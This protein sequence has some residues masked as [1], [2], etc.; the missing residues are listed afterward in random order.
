MVA[1]MKRKA[2]IKNADKLFTSKNKLKDTEEDVEE[3]EDAEMEEEE[4]LPDEEVNEEEKLAKQ[5]E[6][7]VAARRKEL[8]VM[9]IDKLK[10][11]VSSLGLDAK[12]KKEAL[13]ES[14][15]S[16]EAKKRAEQREHEAKVRG[17]V[18]AKTQELQALPMPELKKLC[19]NAN[20][21]GVLSKTV[22]IEQLLRLWCEDDGINKAL[23]KLA[24]Q[25]RKD[26]LFS[27][28]NDALKVLCEGAGID[29]CVKEV[30][31]D[32]LV[33]KE[34]ELGRFNPPTA[35]KKEEPKPCAVKK[36]DMVDALI[37]NEASRKKEA[38]LEKQRVD[39][40]AAKKKE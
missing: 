36:V 33:Q 32:R 7:T 23:A 1:A 24:Y 34:A 2:V 19:D 4:G 29:T 17:V 22:R 26:Q 20:I 10:E 35:V 14:V 30:M 9:H 15:A 31:V 38:A 18:V 25:A 8:K 6:E 13:I 12:Q 21:K 11:L 37:A 27:M 39:A 40:V 16:H 3:Q 5:E 28:D